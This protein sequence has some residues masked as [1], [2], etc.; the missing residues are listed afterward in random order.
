MSE[1][2]GVNVAQ[3]S[4]GD[5]A[6]EDLVD[7]PSADGLTHRRSP[8]R[9]KDHVVLSGSRAGITLIQ[10]M[11]IQGQQNAVDRDSEVELRLGPGT[12][13]VAPP[14]NVEV[15]SW[16]AAQ[17]TSPGID[18]TKSRRVGNEMCILTTETQG[19]THSHS[20]QGKQ[21]DQEPVASSPRTLEQAHDFFGRCLVGRLIMSTRL[22]TP[23]PNMDS[24]RP[25][26]Q[27]IEGTKNL[28]ADR[29]LGHRKPI[30]LPHRDE[31]SVDPPG[32][33]RM[34]FPAPG[35][36]GNCTQLGNKQ[37]KSTGGQSKVSAAHPGEIESQRTRVLGIG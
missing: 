33:A 26:V 37:V 3:S 25:R 34:T 30:K 2:M 31:D 8:Q 15:L 27:F 19:L 17:D 1:H 23:M 4:R 36:D 32:A 24:L 18:E 11:L 10:V 6:L 9:D 5:Q 12:V 29:P 16:S 14:D 7:V 21:H 13:R 35:L 20:S 28:C 22:S